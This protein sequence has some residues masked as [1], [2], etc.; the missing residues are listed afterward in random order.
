MLDSQH[1]VPSGEC[2]EIKRSFCRLCLHSGHLERPCLGPSRRTTRHL[3]APLDH[4]SQ[5]CRDFGRG[6]QP[7]QHGDVSTVDQGV[8]PRPAQRF[9]GGSNMLASFEAGDDTR[10]KINYFLNSMFLCRVTTSP[11]REA[12][13]YVGE[14]KCL[15]DELFGCLWDFVPQF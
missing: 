6:H 4:C 15:N 7:L 3:R 11:Y 5:T 12:V 9:Q 2:S 8:N 14:N 13:L 10:S 1:L